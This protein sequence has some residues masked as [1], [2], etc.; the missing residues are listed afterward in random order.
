MEHF[1]PKVK[2]LRQERNMTREEFCGDESELSVRQ[3]AR[4]ESGVSLPTLNKVHFIA[5]RLRLSIG[6]LTEGNNFDVP[7]RYKE[8]KY[9]I[10]R[11][12][13]YAD[14]ERLKERE[15]QFD[16]IYNNYYDNLPEE[17]KLT[18]DCMQARLDVTISNNV[19]FGESL[20]EEYFEQVKRKRLYRLNELILVDLYLLCVMT[21]SFDENIYQENTFNK[22][23]KTALK[24]ADAVLGEEALFLCR[25]IISFI[26][27]YISLKQSEMIEELLSTCDTI[28]Q[29]AQDF[30]SLPILRLMEW[31]YYLSCKNDMTKAMESYQQ[32]VMFANMIGDTALVGRLE[33]EWQKDTAD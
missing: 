1:G 9:K 21:S 8:L 17:E 27:I 31:K 11:I 20:L 23:V 19:N 14:A 33:K 25:L 13:T 24:R 16:E 18:I 29:R 26:Y 22:I 2:Q 32:A 30:Q 10:L 3:L 12:P 5:D 4:I 15:E 7:E 28:M 6:E